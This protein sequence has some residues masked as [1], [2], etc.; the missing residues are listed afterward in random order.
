MKLSFSKLVVSGLVFAAA[1]A[2]AQEP[3]QNI[4]PRRHGNLATAQDMVRD[5]YDKLTTA[6]VDNHA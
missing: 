5:A 1:A 2:C 3:A 6:Q 4:D